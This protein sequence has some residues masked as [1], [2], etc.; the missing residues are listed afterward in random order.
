MV[1][2]V[3]ETEAVVEMA[4]TVNDENDEKQQNGGNDEES[5]R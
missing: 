1:V 4:V 2:V 3:A 5:G